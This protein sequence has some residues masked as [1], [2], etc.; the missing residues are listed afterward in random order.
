MTDKGSISF[1]QVKH[2]VAERKGVNL[3]HATTKDAQTIG[4]I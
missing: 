4:I 2:E 3:K 1:S